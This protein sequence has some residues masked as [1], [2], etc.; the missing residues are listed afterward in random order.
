MKRIFLSILSFVLLFYSSNCQAKAFLISSE[1]EYEKYSEHFSAGD[2]I[3]WK[4]GTY[5]DIQWEI[6]TSGL[7]VISETPGGV[8]FT[9]SS[10]LLLSADSVIVSGFQFKDGIILGNV[11]EIS[12]SRNKIYGI[13]IS[14][15]DSHYF[16]YITTKGRY[17]II[18]A[19]NFEKKI[20]AP[21]GKEGTSIFQVAVDSLQP[22]YNVIR[23]CSFKNHTAPENSGGDYGMEALRI[24]YSYQAKYISRTIVEYCLFTHCNGDGE[25]ISNKA[26]ENIFRYNTF[27]DNGESH[28]TLRHG[29]DNKVY[30]N[31]FLNGAGIRIKEGQN[32]NVYNNYF[33]TGRF[34]SIR[35][36]NHKADPVKNIVITNNT[37]AESGS[38]RFGGR[39][40]YQPDDVHVVNNIFI[41][42]NGPVVDDLTGRENFGSNGISGTGELPS[43]SG[44]FRM[45]S[46]VELNR[47]GF[48]EPS[49]GNSSE[50]MF[51]EK[52]PLYDIPVLAD[53][54]EIQLDI[55]GN[56]RKGEK[57]FLGSY[58]PGKNSVPVTLHATTGNTGPE[59]L[60]N[61][62]GQITGYRQYIYKLADTLALK[63]FIKKPL[64]ANGIYN[65]PAIVFFF[66]GGWNSGN[67]KQFKPHADYFA[68]RGMVAILADYRVKSRHNTTP[69]DAVADAKSVI[70]YLK[71]Y[72]QALSIDSSAI[73]ASGGSAGGHLAAA[74]ATVTGLDDADDD[75]TIDAKPDALV[76]FNPVFD[77]GPNGY[78]YDRIGE[79]YIEISPFHNIKPGTPP[80]I[81]F[82]GTND[83]LIPVET[84]E[85]FKQKMERSGNKYELHLYEDQKH[86]FFNYRGIS[87]DNNIYY[88]KT[89]F[90]ADKFLVSL[91]FLNQKN[92]Y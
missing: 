82:L 50:K 74:A 27:K 56:R 72:S 42:P 14:G 85:N 91:G 80:T 70:R 88:K 47:Y 6:G 53:D 41:S 59:Y 25:I 48:Y 33:N 81:V 86:G 10:K 3:I 4:N 79:R 39:G 51:S 62:T 23:Y 57:I 60:D 24:G 29:S 52:I 83:R 89:L 76:L 84:A 13:N 40:E 21:P 31:F 44:F 45:D 9:G 7:M 35:L 34:F 61:Q 38:I 68:S 43:G 69:F 90:A 66:G 73:V 71:R 64:E 11:F 77:N 55:A 30:G 87:T 65:Y 28:L 22:G 18:E 19:C 12:G 67:I 37:F 78:G 75:S 2:T 46:S 17:N 63:L 16:F 58:E 36:E 54:P 1:G 32:Q 5:K 20:T 15:Y 49:V 8:V 26:R 92:N